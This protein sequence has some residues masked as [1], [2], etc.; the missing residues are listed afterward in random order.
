MAYIFA[1][2]VSLVVYLLGGWCMFSI[3]ASVFPF[4]YDA[5]FD[6]VG[7]TQIIVYG[8]WTMLVSFAAL[9]LESRCD[10]SGSEGDSLTTIMLLAPACLWIWALCGFPLSIGLGIVNA[11][12]CVASLTYFI[13]GWFKKI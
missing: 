9:Y 4:D 3:Y 11:V 5:T 8:I 13:G 1:F 7:R 12:V 6:S 2:L 10:S